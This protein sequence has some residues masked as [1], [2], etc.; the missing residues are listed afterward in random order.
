MKRK[1]EI[2]I[3]LFPFYLL[4]YEM[5]KKINMRRSGDVMTKKVK[6][7][8][9]NGKNHLFAHHHMNTER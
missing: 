4:K 9:E 7:K 5:R 6:R 3:T 1:S 8:E 2:S